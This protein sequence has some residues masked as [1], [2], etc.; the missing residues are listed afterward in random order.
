MEGR[1]FGCSEIYLVSRQVGKR[2]IFKVRT[3]LFY[4]S[5]CPAFAVHPNGALSN[6]KGVM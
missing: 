2:A 6:L 3:E 1:R 4:R 5:G